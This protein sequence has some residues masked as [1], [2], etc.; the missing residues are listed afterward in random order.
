[1]GEDYMKRPYLNRPVLINMHYDIDESRIKV[2][3]DVT[4]FLSLNK[5]RKFKQQDLLEMYGKI[6]KLA[7]QCNLK[8]HYTRYIKKNI[9]SHWK[10]YEEAVKESNNEFNEILK[11]VKEIQKRGIHIGYADDE[12]LHECINRTDSR[13]VKLLNGYTNMIT[14][15][16]LDMKHLLAELE[17]YVS[18]NKKF[19]NGEIYL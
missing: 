15:Y 14:G 17:E 10:D 11:M 5:V 1:M 7:R 16:Y 8:V 18:K 4:L 13:E 6:L 12:L 9:V 19:E 2:Y 3:N